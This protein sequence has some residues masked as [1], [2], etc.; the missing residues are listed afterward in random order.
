[1]F[2]IEKRWLNW[3]R[4]SYARNPQHHRH[5]R[6][7]N[8]SGDAIRQAPIPPL[9]LSEQEQK[10]DHK[11]LDLNQQLNHRVDHPW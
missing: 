6:P 4:N 10:V 3:Y 9:V 11:K 8:W 2:C 7:D 5:R 1:M